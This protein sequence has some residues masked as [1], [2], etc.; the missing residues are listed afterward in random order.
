MVN[1]CEKTEFNF[2]RYTLHFENYSQLIKNYWNSDLKHL[3]GSKQNLGL[4][5]RPYPLILSSRLPE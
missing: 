2:F 1:F 4:Q 3:T 5:E